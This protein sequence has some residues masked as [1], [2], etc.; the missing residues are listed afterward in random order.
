LVEERVGKRAGAKARVLVR[1]AA[2]ALE[3]EN[4]TRTECFQKGKAMGSQTSPEK[5]VKNLQKAVRRSLL[6]LV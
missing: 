2:K 1:R 4:G 3:K 6:L 5:K